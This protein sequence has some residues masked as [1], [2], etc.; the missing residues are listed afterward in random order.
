MRV[1][2]ISQGRLATYAE[3]E[4]CAYETD[5]SIFGFEGLGEVSY[6]KELKGE[7]RFFENVAMV[8]KREQNVVVCGCVT[9]TRG[10]K[11]KSVAV[12]EKGKLLGVS[13]LLHAIDGEVGSGASLKLYETKLG[14]IGVMVA[15][16]LYFSDGLRALA[17]CGCD[18]IVCPFGKVEEIHSVLLRAYAYCYGIPIFF[19][20][21][22]YSMIADPSG[23][24][25]FAT[26][27]SPVCTEYT[28][29]REYHVIETRNR[30]CYHPC[31]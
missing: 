1:G 6:E 8:S 19:C 23:E 29:S 28:G 9:D 4:R 24:I 11:R 13:D 2:F 12:A 14:K 30:G 21:I 17:L 7:T 18:F 15:E 5:I 27:I 25:T 26:P 22:G 10:Y 3:K 31:I 16:D 20:G